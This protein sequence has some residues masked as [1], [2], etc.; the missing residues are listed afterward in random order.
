MPSASLRA[1]VKWTVRNGWLLWAIALILGVP[2]TARTAFL[3]LHLR[4]E[5]EQLLPREAP[6]V[7]ALDEMR[8][9]NPGL[10]FLGVVAQ[11]NNADQLPMAERFLEDLAARVRSYP[12]QIVHDVRT[13]GAVEKEFIEKHAA[14]YMDLPD[15]RELRRRLEA[16]RDYEVAKEQGALLDEGE[17][18]PAPQARGDTPGAATSLTDPAP[19]PP[20]LDVSDIE[21]KY[22]EHLSG[23][24]SDHFE[25]TALRAAL[26]TIETG[27]FT[28]GVAGGRKLLDRVKADV[29]TLGPEHYASG[30]RIGY[31]SDVAINVEELDALQ[32]DLS[33]SSVL[34]V[35]LVMTVLVLY[36]GWYRSVLVL[37]PPLLL[38]TVY[39]FALASLPPFGVTELNSNTA[40]LGSIIVGNGINVGIILLARYREQRMRL[41]PVDEAL[42]VAVWGARPGTLAAAAAAAASYA[43]LVVTEFRGFRQFG[44]IGGLGMMASWATAFLL[45]PPLLKWLDTGP[46]D[47]ATAGPGRRLTTRIILGSVERGAL[48]IVAG[49][50]LLT[51]AS[52]VKAWHL[53]SS[54]LESDFNKLRRSD[55][56]KNGEGYWGRKMD[57]ILGH[58]LT[59]TL[60]LCDTIEQAGRVEARVRASVDHGVLAPMVAR[61]L[62]ASDILP[63]DQRAKIAEVAAIR[64]T[65][66]PKI[67]SLIAP[68]RL[69]RLDKL[70]GS[71]DLAPIHEA[72]LPGSLT[73]GLRERDGTM[74]RAILVYPRPSDA[75]WKVDS[76]HLF[77]GTLRELAAAG[78]GGEQPGRV[79]G[80][81]PLSSDILGSIRRDA[82][83]AS[84][85]SFAGVV[86]VVFLV[87]RAR[88]ASL[89]VIASL[90]VGALWL[91]GATLA[92]GIKINFTNFI[93][94]PITFG[95][96][97]DYAV[98][99][100]TRYVQ[101][102]EHD[103]RGA[104]RSTGGAVALCSLTTI[105]GYSSLLLAKNRAL[106][107]FGLLAVIGEVACLAAAVL[108][109]PSWLVLRRR[110]LR[111]ASV[112]PAS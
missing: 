33:A 16:R 90:L 107:L 26:L 98:N 7:R 74:G 54:Q 11:V 83:I 27:D 41:V 57:A 45:I 36:Y 91:L 105:I 88:A 96:G 18:P 65:L 76:M 71:G 2:A 62:S 60:T 12:P 35:V 75:L 37:I 59:P 4:S 51:G 56:W 25:S 63:T 81:I 53:D 89:Y 101:D 84:I 69:E 106:F 86:A 19:G 70:L 82:P 40:F 111:P 47:P 66:T 13:G 32:A 55:T 64:E 29:S 94:F 93:A 102:G 21:A 43:S 92:L 9:R 110:G 72:E 87:V 100:M 61:V 104:V 34:V 48:W 73:T 52:I 103:V 79:A 10:A 97:V 67:R 109:L 85:V 22:H 44:I 38:A 3:Y 24:T 14:L 6:S 1:W 8:A 20:S 17:A 39:S 80:Q 78:T 108:A 68:D 58:Y 15:L 5:I 30:L 99:V 31:A 50:L 42:V 77:V 23:E 112:A 95:I 49:A 28:T 46:L